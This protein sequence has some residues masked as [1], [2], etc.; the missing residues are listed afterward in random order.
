MSQ[1]PE[2]RAD[3]RRK[4]RARTRRRRVASLVGALGLLAGLAIAGFALSGT[5]KHESSA[6]EDDRHFRAR[7]CRYRVALGT[8]GRT[9][10]PTPRRDASSDYGEEARGNAPVSDHD[11]CS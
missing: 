10:D 4:Q 3:R 5:G 1:S 7:R 11:H 2:A 6:R 9:R 8:A